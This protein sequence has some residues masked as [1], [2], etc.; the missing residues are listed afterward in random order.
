MK[1]FIEFLVISIILFSCNKIEDEPK[2]D[3]IIYHKFEPFLY[4]HSIRQ[5]ISTN[6]MWSIPVPND[7]ITKCYIDI[8]EDSVND[9]YFE[10]RHEP[11]KNTFSVHYYPLRSFITI[12]GLRNNVLFGY[13]KS[14]FTILMYDSINNNVVKSKSDWIEK[15]DLHREGP[16][17]SGC[18]FSDGYIGV[19]VEN[20]LGWIHVAPGNNNGIIIMEYAFNTT[21][22][23]PITIKNSY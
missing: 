14:A 19:K 2:P 22:D 1:N 21:A 5:Y 20:N 23:N 18:S 17:I 6:P 16:V 13:N 15:L 12:C 7:S 4:V 10:A 11:D 9:F 8:N 3:K